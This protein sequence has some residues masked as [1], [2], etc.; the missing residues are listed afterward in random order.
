[1]PTLYA[2]DKA[3]GEFKKVG[4]VSGSSGDIPTKTSQLENDSGFITSYTETDPTVPTWAKESNKPSYTASEVG[5]DP[6]GTA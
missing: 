5:A 6:S 2:K 4:P 3:T 1:M